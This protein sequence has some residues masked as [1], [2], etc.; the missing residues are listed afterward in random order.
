MLVNFVLWLM[1]RSPAARRL[2][3]RGFHELLGHRYGGLDWWT[4]MNYGFA[5][6]GEDPR[7]IPLAPE[8]EAERYCAQL[9]AHVTG[10]VDLEGRDVLE[11]GC[12]RG[13][14]V[15][16]VARYLNPR[17]ATGLDAARTQVD[18]CRRVHGGPKVE[19]VHGEAERLPFDDDSFDAVV[20]VESSF[21]YRDMDAFLAEVRRVLRPGGHFLFADVRLAFEADALVDQLARAGFTVIGARDISGNVCRA[22]ELDAERRRKVA[23]TLVPAYLRHVLYA[24]VGVEGTRIPTLLSSGLLRYLSVTMQKDGA[25]LAAPIRGTVAARTSE[26]RE[27]VGAEQAARQGARVAGFELTQRDSPAA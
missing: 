22:L 11:V 20:N 17:R 19:F 6:L 10:A 14:G 24:F 1:R 16:Y 7:P 3:W 25:Q 23:A 15:S 9:Y 4:F 18:F 13:G 8:D 21:C 5:E 2:A 27:L 12:G 26:P